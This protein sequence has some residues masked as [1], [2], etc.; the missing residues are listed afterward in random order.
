MDIHARVVH[1]AYLKIA[2]WLILHRI[3]WLI[4]WEDL[5]HPL[6][7]SPTHVPKDFVPLGVLMFVPIF[8]EISLVL[9]RIVVQIAIAKVD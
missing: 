8:V 1:N 7:I 9:A 6:L 5:A 4:N 2:P 3:A